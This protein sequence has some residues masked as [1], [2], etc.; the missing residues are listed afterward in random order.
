MSDLPQ[1]P[2]SD[3]SQTLDEIERRRAHALEQMK[4]FAA[5]A[6]EMARDKTQLE[7][8]AAKMATK[9]GLKVSLNGMPVEPQIAPA[10]LTVGQLIARYR[11][12]LNSPYRKLQHNSRQNY[13]ALIGLIER[14][15]SAVRIS[16][17]NAAVLQQWYEKWKAGN[18]IAVAH[19]KM[20]MLRNL[21]GFGFSE[22]ANEECARLSGILS[23][24]QLELPKARNQQLTRDQANSIRAKAHEKKRPSVAL[25]Q[26]FQFEV[27]L[28][29]KDTIGE[30]VPISEV[31]V[32]D[33]IQDGM[34]WVRGLRWEEIDGDLKLTHLAGDKEITF[35]LR[36]A[37]MVL[38]ELK[39]LKEANDGELPAGGPVVRSEW[40]NLPW[41]AVE[42]RRWWRVL[43]NEC[44]IPKS[45]RNSDS[46]S[47]AKEDEKE[48]T[49]G[50]AVR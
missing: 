4:R 38:E 33:V 15:Y 45:V 40:D 19:S 42:Y 5:E 24:M 21:F 7:E 14:E 2:L 50:R 3:L 16:E 9:Y 17:I 23:K 29:Q 25:A 28:T 49:G 48:A 47:R 36:N 22:L 1:E 13:D 35:D 37:P 44:G 10:D 27:G 43:A 32:S 30:W 41:S 6:E 12:N 34:K 26:A 18:K 8:L 39:R 31:G 20:V 11:S 46:R